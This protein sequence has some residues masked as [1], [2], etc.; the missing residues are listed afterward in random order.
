VN[1]D[2][3]TSL[4]TSIRDYIG[5]PEGGRGVNGIL[6]DLKNTLFNGGGG[7]SGIGDYLAAGKNYAATANDYLKTSNDL[8]GAVAS[9]LATANE[10]LGALESGRGVNGILIDLKNTLFNGGGVYSGLG[11]YLAAITTT[12]DTIATNTGG[13]APPDSSGTLTNILSAINTGNGHLN[14]IKTSASS[15]VSQL[16]TSGVIYTVLIDTKNTLF[17]GGGGYSGIGVYLAAMRNNLKRL[18]DAGAGVGGGYATGGI[19]SGPT[20]GYQATLHGTEAIIPLGDGN[21]VTAHLT[22]PLPPA[23]NLIYREA[24]DS[25]G[26]RQAL[27]ELQAEVQALRSDQQAAAAATVGELRDHNRRERKRDVVGQKVE[28]VS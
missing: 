12:L 19:A 16:G 7:Y 25:Q 22:S 18:V 2:S 21:S 6:I 13:N 15:T 5:P 14:N 10:R 20:S 9:T 1:G 17:N 3:L 11:V 24:G 26:L 28:V 4:L 27:A 23:P 8:A